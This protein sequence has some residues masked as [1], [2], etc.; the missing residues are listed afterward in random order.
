MNCELTLNFDTKEWE[1]VVTD[2]GLW[3]DVFI[4]FTSNGD[5]TVF[6]SLSFGYTVTVNGDLLHEATFPPEGTVYFQ[7]DQPYIIV[8]RVLGFNPDDEIV[9]ALHANNAG[10]AY[11]D[12][13]SWTVARPPQP[14]SDCVWNDELKNWDCPEEYNGTVA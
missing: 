10:V 5:T 4:G 11:A 2:N 1:V 8:D 7:T 3:L 14:N 13:E 12:I 9:L 6:D